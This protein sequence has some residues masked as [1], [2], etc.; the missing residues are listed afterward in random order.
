MARFFTPIRVSLS[1]ILISSEG[2]VP[3]VLS[4]RRLTPSGP[5][6]PVFPIVRTD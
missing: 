5:M 1:T 4:Y 6:M 2:Q 3:E